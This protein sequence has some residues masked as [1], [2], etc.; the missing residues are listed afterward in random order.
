M[1]AIRKRPGR[2]KPWE[3]RYRDPSGRS[4]SRS[5]ARKVDAQRFLTTLEADKLRGSWVDPAAGRVTFAAFADQWL[6]AQVFDAKT[7]EGAASRLRA[8]LV[9]AFGATELR[10]I[11]PSTVQAWVARASRDL[12]PSHVRLLLSTL[13]A[14]L[15]AAVEDGLI[16]TNP[17]RSRAVS[18]PQVPRRK[19]QPWTVEQV[20]AVVAAMQDRYRGTAVVASGCGLRQGE[21]FGLRV[22]DVDFLRRVLHVRQQAKHVTGQGVVIAPPKGRRTR[23]VPLPD[24]VAAVLSEHLRAYPAAGDDLVFTNSTGGPINRGSYNTRVWK[25]ALR[26]AGIAA[27]RINGM[28]ML[29]HTFASV[30]LADGVSIRALAEYLSHADPAFT[31]RVYTHL[32]PDDDDRARRVLDV[33]LGERVGQAWARAVSD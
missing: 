8:H 3:A 17:C 20:A 32:M 4:R 12:A 28:H 19:V 33:A 1:A 9:P 11:R 25:P 18:A 6:A 27:T 15:G 5:F 26:A 21:V 16:V 2:P 7:H 10:A 13:S 23:I 24:T 22:A 31:L 30:L 14:I 29:R